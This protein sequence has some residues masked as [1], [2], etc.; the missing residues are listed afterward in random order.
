MTENEF[1]YWLKGFFEISGDTLSSLKAVQVQTISSHLE[2]VFDKK[3]PKTSSIPDQLSGRRHQPD[4]TMV[5]STATKLTP[6]NWT[7]ST[8]DSGSHV[9][10]SC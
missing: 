2:L 6:Y 5:Y 10:A 1:C 9:K 7:E 3:T 4:P 8:T